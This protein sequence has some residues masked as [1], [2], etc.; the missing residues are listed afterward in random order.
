MI[1]HQ[2][3]MAHPRRKQSGLGIIEVLVALVVVS[4]GVLGMASLQLTGMKHSSGS[5]NR[6]KALLFAQSMAT[7]IRINTEAVVTS[8]YAGFDSTGFNCDV[9][10]APYCQAQPGGTAAAACNPSELA[11]FDLYSVTCGD[12]GSG[13]ADKGVAGS[14][15]NG[16]LA[17]VCLNA[18]CTPASAYQVT[19]T[20]SEGRS[21]TQN[22]ELVSRRVQVR[23]RP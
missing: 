14:L 18:P 21:R 4:F 8:D 5:F 7:R 9:P 1:I 16:S 12:L 19:V 6:A 22:D 17:V 2:R 11:T 15:P 23:L 10:P 13:G 3:R 20:W